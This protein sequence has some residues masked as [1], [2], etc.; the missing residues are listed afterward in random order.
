MAVTSGADEGTG[1]VAATGATWAEM[2]ARAMVVA[3]AMARGPLVNRTWLLST[4]TRRTTA[5]AK[6]WRRP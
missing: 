2:L 4:G 1:S 3:R 5:V 6:G